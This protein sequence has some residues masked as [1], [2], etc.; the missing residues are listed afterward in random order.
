MGH[1][2]FTGL[3]RRKIVVRVLTHPKLV[4]LGEGV[5]VEV[6]GADRGFEL[7]SECDNGV[8]TSGHHNSAAY[9]KN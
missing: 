7:L 6:G 1:K 3:L 5:V 9:K 2:Y 8:D 4:G